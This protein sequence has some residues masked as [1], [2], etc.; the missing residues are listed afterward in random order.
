MLL[1]SWTWVLLVGFGLVSACDSSQ[2]EPK[3][4]EGDA[5]KDAAAPPNHPDDR[6]DAAPPKTEPEMHE[7]FGYDWTVQP[8]VEAYWCGYQTL[9]E[10]LYIS[11]FHPRMPPGTHHLV[12]GYQDPVVPD[13]YVDAD[14]DATT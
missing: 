10:D 2:D 9:K 5:G 8:S 7:L 13:G 6:P 14:P 12:V 3:P 1:R 4:N 11:R